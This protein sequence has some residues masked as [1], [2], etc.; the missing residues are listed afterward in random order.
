MQPSGEW[1]DGEGGK[2]IGNICELESEGE[3]SSEAEGLGGDVSE[4]G[5][6]GNT[7]VLQLSGTVLVESGLVNVVGET[8]WIPEASGADDTKLILVGRVEGGGG[9]LVAGWGKGSSGGD[10]GGENGRLH[11]GS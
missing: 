10:E 4:D 11:G 8:A 1:N 7:S 5:H 2:T 9:G 6:H 3:F